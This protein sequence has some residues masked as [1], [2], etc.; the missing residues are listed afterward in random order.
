[1]LYLSPLEGEKRRT[2]LRSIG[3]Q[4]RVKDQM[5][6]AGVDVSEPPSTESRLPTYTAHLVPCKVR[7]TGPTEEFRDNFHV[8][9]S[10]DESLQKA[11]SGAKQGASH[12]SYLRGRKI[13]GRDILPTK[14][15]A[16]FLMS[17]S[18]DASEAPAYT[19]VAKLSSVINY[20]RDGNEERLQEEVSKFNE[21]V[22]FLDLVHS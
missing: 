20:E 4:K 3:K 19:P 15:H 16:A 17:N 5:T 1:M 14:D 22:E 2:L 7:Y 10:H 11:E 9:P 8:D 13:S 12:V 6:D 21:L 18:S